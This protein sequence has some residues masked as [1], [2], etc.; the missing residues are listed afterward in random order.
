MGRAVAQNTTVYVADENAGRLYALDYGT[1][2]FVERVGYVDGGTPP[3]ICPTY[4][5]DLLVSPAP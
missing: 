3:Q 1:N 2:S 4:I 5:S